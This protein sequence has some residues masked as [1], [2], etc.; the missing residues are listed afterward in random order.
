[1]DRT[2]RTSQWPPAHGRRPPEPGT[3][4]NHPACPATT[5]RAD[6]PDSGGTHPETRVHI[7][8]FWFPA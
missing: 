5:T 1:M 6:A 8:G 7:L 2:R 3:R 4:M